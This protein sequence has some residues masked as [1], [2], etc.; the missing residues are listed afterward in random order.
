MITKAK[1]KQI[2]KSSPLLL[3]AVALL[4]WLSFQEEG[5]NIQPAPPTDDSAPD[6]ILIN[7]V[8]T[9]YDETGQQ[10]YQL[11]ATKIDHFQES[12]IA[13]LEKP[14]LINQAED[15]QWQANALS[16]RADLNSDTL[17]LKD[18]VKIDKV[19]ATQTVSL[20]TSELTIDTQKNTAE[21]DVLT[22]I[23]SG[24][25]FIESRGFFT[26]FNTS[27][28]LLKSNVRGTHDVQK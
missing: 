3:A 9:H 25:S 1:I 6:L 16:G 21:N 22:V 17:F 13:L 11:T 19:T 28:T 10:Q 24:P 26:D 14:Y 5:N 12:H 2:L 27:E 15:A 23:H 20:R 8:S 4:F 7:S 18:Q